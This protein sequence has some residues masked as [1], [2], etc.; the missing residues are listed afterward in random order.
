VS[1]KA[2]KR[3]AAVALVA[4]I[5]GGALAYG[6]VSGT[7][8]IFNAETENPNSA[9]LGSWIPPPTLTSTALNGSPY[10]TEHLVWVSGN[11]TVMP[12]AAANP[13]TGQALLYADGGSAAAAVC[14]AAGSG[15]YASFT[16]SP[17]L[18]A[19]STTSDV[20]GTNVPDWWCWE[21]QSTSTSATTSGAWTS[22]Y[23]AF[24]SAQSKRLFVLTGFSQ[25]NT[26]G[27]LD[28]AENGDQIVL[29]F[30]QNRGVIGAG[31]GTVNVRICN[32]GTILV[33]TAAI[34]SCAVTPNIGAITGQTIST[35]RNCTGSTTTG[36]G[37]TTL[38]IT[39]VACGGNSSVGAGTA[40]FTV[41]GTGLAATAGT[42]LCSSTSAPDCRA[43]TTTR[44]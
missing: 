14:P 31:N 37:T 32:T 25:N 11:S 33:S 44:Y 3:A 10:A 19:T 39:L 38:T 20:T 40:T 36:N 27:T 8:A 29:T 23:K 35:N 18:T 42:N 43:T 30:N 4:L 16:P 6:Q 28:K 13:V 17:V 21:L 34:G 15:S 5:A 24:T 7:F 9:A 1:Q 26:G 41:T 2:R 12:G 22:D